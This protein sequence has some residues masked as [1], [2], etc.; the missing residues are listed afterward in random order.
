MNGFD[1]SALDAMQDNWHTHIYPYKIASY[2]NKLLCEPVTLCELDYAGICR[3]SSTID[4]DQDQDLASSMFGVTQKTSMQLHTV[5]SAD[6][7]A[8][9]VDF[10]LSAEDASS[11]REGESGIYFRG[12][13]GQNF[14]SYLTV[15]LKFFASPIQVAVGG[16]IDCTSVLDTAV[17]DF[18][19][20]FEVRTAMS[21][22]E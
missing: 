17:S 5:G 22:I 15:N 6:A 4:D 19:Y 14:L 10:Q 18:K 3:K 8:V 7:V 11:E 13:D 16:I 1:H 20:T 12:H 21:R 9:W 2:K